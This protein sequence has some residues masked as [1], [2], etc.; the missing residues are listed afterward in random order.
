MFCTTK[1]DL[2]VEVGSIAKHREWGLRLSSMANFHLLVV[3]IV[4]RKIS[5]KQKPRE[6]KK[7]KKY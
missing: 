7:R 2:G 6:K 1:R 4:R 3:G 5:E